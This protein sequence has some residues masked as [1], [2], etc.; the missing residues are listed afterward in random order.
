MSG[1]DRI[2]SRASL[3]T[4]RFTTSSFLIGAM[5]I[6][7]TCLVITVLGGAVG[8]AY[9]SVAYGGVWDTAL[10]AAAA[11]CL[12]ALLYCATFL[13]EGAYTIP[14][15]CRASATIAASLGIV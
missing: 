3:R 1:I 5:S 2:A 12:V 15:S 10:R 11:G 9:H 6:A 7:A 14:S 4:P 8:A 13:S